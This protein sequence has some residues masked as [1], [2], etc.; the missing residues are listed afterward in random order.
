MTLDDLIKQF[1]GD[2]DGLM[3]ALADGR[4]TAQGFIT[5][6]EASIAR[7]HIAAMLAGQQAAELSEQT[8]EALVNL[9]AVQLGFVAGFAKLLKALGPVGIGDRIKKLTWRAKLYARAIPIAFEQGQTLLKYG[10]ILP[11]PAMPKQGTQCGNNCK[12]RISVEEID[13]ERGDFN[14]YWERHADDSC[15]TCVVREREWNGPNGDRTR[16]MKI[17]GWRLMQ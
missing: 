10:R 12:C 14:G 1:D 2:I 3:T 13:R 9:I 16:P 15:Q 4:L 11:W 8:V 17:R 6:F 5:E 7:Y